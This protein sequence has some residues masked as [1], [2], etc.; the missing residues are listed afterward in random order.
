MLYKS[1]EDIDVLSMSINF[2]RCLCRSFWLAPKCKIDGEKARVK[3]RY[4]HYYYS[5]T[6]ILHFCRDQLE[7]N[8]KLRKV[9][10]RE[11]ENHA[12]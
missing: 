4:K 2:G 6:L 12:I 8:V 7:L 9:E 5:G 11:N 3:F 10:S 1:S